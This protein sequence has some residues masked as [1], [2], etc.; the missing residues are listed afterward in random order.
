MSALRAHRRG[1]PEQLALEPA[2][3]PPVADDEALIEVHAAA[4]TFAELGWDEVWKHLPMIPS[5]EVS[6]VVVAVGRSVTWP[7]VGDQVY[8]LIRFDRDGAA[9]EYVSVPAADLAPRPRTV[10]HTVAAA[11][12]LAALTAWQALVDQAKVQPGERVLVHGGAGGVG[13]YVTQIAARLGARVTATAFTADVAHVLRLGAHR[14]IDVATQQFDAT[15]AAFDVVIDTVGG[16]TLERSYPVLVAGG[17]LVTLQAPPSA[18]MVA[19][20]GIQ[21]LF[22]VVSPNRDELSAL[23]AMV[24]AGELEVKI[25]STF[26][27]SAGRAAFESGAHFDRPPGKTVLLVRD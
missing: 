22:F 3:T 27:L 1:G 24:D 26:P 12:P 18:E 25:A 17:R 16:A 6:G 13:S 23:A 5:H 10:G 2:P 14:V 8:G 11:V 9:A 19:R 20:H 7:Q 21:G 15:P 4:I